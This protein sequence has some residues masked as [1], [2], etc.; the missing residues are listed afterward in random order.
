MKELV[1]ALDTSAGT[2]VAVAGDGVVLAARVVDDTRSHAERVAPLIREALAEAGATVH[3]LTLIAV[4]M[5]PGPFT[6]LR[7]GIATAATLATVTPVPLLHVGSLDVI[8]AGA[9]A[10][11]VAGEFLAV[12]DARRKEVYWARYDATGRR[13]EGP[14]VSPPAAL[15]ALPAVGP[16]AA[17]CPQATHV[18]VRP[19]DVTFLATHPRSFADVGPEPLYLRRPDAE[20]STRRKS[21]LAAT[22]RS[23]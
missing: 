20:V 17:L 18:D 21:A 3:D 8:A 11:G 2:A 4:G 1:L 22:E 23:K 7:V 5:G 15:P 6:G 10:Q 19:V 14:G 9:A 16:G 13:V 12:L